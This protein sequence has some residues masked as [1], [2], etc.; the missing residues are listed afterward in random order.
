MT[1]AT[2]SRSRRRRRHKLT[3]GTA[4]ATTLTALT[5]AVLTGCATSSLSP[6]EVPEIVW[7]TDEPTGPLEDDEWVKTVRTYGILSSVA[8]NAGDY[9]DPALATVAA[10]QRIQ[11]T[12]SR[13]EAEAGRSEGQIL[14]AG[15]TPF[16]P[17]T[18]EASTSGDRAVVTGCAVEGWIIDAQNLDPR[19]EGGREV[20]YELKRDDHD[21]P[22][23]VAVNSMADTC[24]PTHIPRAVFDPAPQVPTRW[25]AP[26]DIR[27]PEYKP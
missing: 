26:D 27:I 18:V 5:T 12:W 24:D 22:Q 9:T 7:I 6:P 25:P 2:P 4:L 8:W 13:R 21:N 10:P 17:V 14:M 19:V 16:T 1:A 15:P 3:D 11:A 20:Q 23:V